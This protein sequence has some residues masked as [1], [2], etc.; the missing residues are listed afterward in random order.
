MY[1]IPELDAR[2]LRNFALLTGAIIIVLV[3]LFFPWVFGFKIPVWPWVL[4]SVLA[5]W[6]LV[7]P[8]TLR[9]VYR[10]WMKFGQLLSKITTPLVL[11]IVFYLVIFPI[12]FVMRMFGRDPMI[13]RINTVVRTYRIPSAKPPKEN[14]ER[15]F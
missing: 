9:P 13:G 3:G 6:G 5:A 15:P 2:G 10:G 14:I 4:A 1:E 12:G 11:G 7:A 8:A